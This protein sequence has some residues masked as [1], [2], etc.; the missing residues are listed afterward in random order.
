MLKTLPVTL[1]FLSGLGLCLLI[2]LAAM[3]WIAPLGWMDHPRGRRQHEHPTPR[4][5][6]LAL[7]A[8]LGIGQSLGAVKL[9]LGP[10]EWGVVY[11]MGLMGALDDRFDLRARWKALASLVAAAILAALTWNLLRQ[12]G[13]HLPLFQGTLATKTGLALALLWA[14]YW[15]IPQACNLI[16]GMNGLALGFF[17]MLA[18]SMDLPL[19]EAGH[20]A[21][22]LGALVALAALNWPRGRQFLGDTGSLSLGTL[23]AI[24]GVHLLAVASPNRLLWAFAYPIVDVLMVMAIRLSIG[25]PLGEGDRNHFHH[26]WLRLFPSRP[27]I[28]LGLTLLPGFACMQVLQ[29]YPGH[30]AVAWAGGAWLAGCAIWFFRRSRAVAPARPPSGG[31]PRLELDARWTEPSGPH[32]AA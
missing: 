15:S 24:L 9:P 1:R 19:G 21:Y 20:G 2:S 30:R 25:K 18:L 22:L 4:T 5:G 26:Q 17:L 3:R 11:G 14:W 12:A 23:F 32:R 16:D 27:T 8:A 31:R 28:A 29:D 13:A 7:L 10:A 6:G